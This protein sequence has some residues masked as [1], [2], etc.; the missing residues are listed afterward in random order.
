MITK[1]EA[2]ESDYNL[3]PSRYIDTSQKESYRPIP[4]ILEELK[5]LDEKSKES[6]EE[7]KKIF[8]QIKL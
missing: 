3:S 4:E 8:S 5:T 2:T 6:D 1:E 7:L